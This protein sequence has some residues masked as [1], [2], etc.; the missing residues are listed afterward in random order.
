MARKASTPPL[1]FKRTEK[2]TWK[3]NLDTEVIEMLELYPTWHSQVT[4]EPAPS[5]EE[6]LEGIVRKVLGGHSEFKKFFDEK[7][8]AGAGAGANDGTGATGRGASKAGAS[9]Q[10]Q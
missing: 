4:G 10:P 2:K 7:R 6:V 5:P 8:S 1:K 9:R 3:G